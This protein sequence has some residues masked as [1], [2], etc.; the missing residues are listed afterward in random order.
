[1]VIFLLYKIIYFQNPFLIYNSKCCIVS[2]SWDD[3]TIRYAYRQKAYRDTIRFQWIV[4]ALS[5]AGEARTRAPRS[6]VKHS[7]TELPG[8]VEISRIFQPCSLCIFA[9]FVGF[10]QF[11]PCLVMQDQEPS[12]WL[13]YLV[14]LLWCSLLWCWSVVFDCDISW[15]YSLAFEKKLISMSCS[16]F[17]FSKSYANYLVQKSLS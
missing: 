5:D 14:L 13:F 11:H 16:P 3:L 15:P 2:V 4:A 9:S 1:M 12:S 6:R 8:R 7:T 17:F 10:F